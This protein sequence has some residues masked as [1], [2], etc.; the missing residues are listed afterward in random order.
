MQHTEE[1]PGEDKESTNL[2]AK[3]RPE[4]EPTMLG[5][6]LRLLYNCEKQISII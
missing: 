2:P 1:N 6:D 4:S 5:T 3:K